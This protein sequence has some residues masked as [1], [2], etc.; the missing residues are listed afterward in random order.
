MG[1]VYRADDLELGQSV[2]L[3]FLNERL[4]ES[5]VAMDRLRREVRIARGISHPNVCRTY[6]ISEEDGHVFVVMEY[7]DGEDL[8]SVLRRLGRPSRDKAV[9]ISRQLCMGV[10]AAHENGILHRD[11]K[12]ANIMIDGRGRVRV[13]DFGL[14]GLVEEL[15]QEQGISG[16]PEYMAPEQLNGKPATVQSDVYA[17]GLILHEVFSGRRIH[18]SGDLREIRER[19]SSGSIIDSISFDRDVDPAVERVISRCL[20]YD[21]KDRPPS[22]YSVLGALPGG[23][24]LAAAVAA[25]ETP[26]PELVAAAGGAGAVRPRVAMACVALVLAT[27]VLLGWS[28]GQRLH[29]L[30]LS[31]SRLALQAEQVLDAAGISE[32]P[33]YTATGFWSEDM[34]DELGNDAPPAFYLRRWSPRRMIPSDLHNPGPLPTDPPQT[35]PGSATVVLDPSGRL[36]GLYAIANAGS[37]SAAGESIDW[38]RLFD[39][40]GT[41]PDLKR[42]A[43]GRKPAAVSDSVLAWI[44]H[45]TTYG[46]AAAHGQVVHFWVDTDWGSTF[47]LGMFELDFG[48]KGGGPAV[49]LPFLVQVLVPLVFS[50]VLTWHNIRAGRGDLRGAI[51][52]AIVIFLAYAVQ[53]LSALNLRELGLLDVLRSMTDEAPVAHALL[54]ATMMWFGYMAI[55][56]YVRRWW[57]RVLVSWARMV[58]GRPRD[59]IVGRD[60]LAGA[61]IAA[62]VMVVQIALERAGITLGL[63]DAR[64]L[65]FID[66]LSLADGG[67]AVGMAAYAFALSVLITMVFFT[68]LFILRLLVRSNRVATVLTMLVYGAMF[69]VFMGDGA[70]LVMDVVVAFVAVGGLALAGLR[71]GLVAALVKTFFHL[72]FMGLP[73]TLDVSAWYTAHALPGALALGL[74]LAYGFWASLGGQSLFS[75]PLSEKG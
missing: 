32:L 67:D 71:F 58:S 38:P 8:A 28:N 35:H 12:P 75:D 61:T 42:V 57:P 29:P 70:S 52:L 25:G 36:L 16:T 74:L 2:A 47:D 45:G 37:T 10:A 1:E 73:W 51:A 41:S 66:L 39:L 60:I 56:P 34:G 21:P 26:S 30:T 7:I 24:P 11:L 19:Q 48:Q 13:T 53:S 54:H 3:K 50:L 23:D 18:E 69:T 40:A 68:E 44:D 33:R 63:K 65:M 14:A 22:S 6:D 9:E 31:A 17:L 27:V 20:E 46:A 15:A 62:G 5:P 43:P 59:P 72:L 4:G 55:E 49:W 64:P